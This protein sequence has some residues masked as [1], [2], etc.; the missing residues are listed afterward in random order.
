[1]GNN[2]SKLI[3]I[4]YEKDIPFADGEDFWVIQHIF[5]RKEID[6]AAF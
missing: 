5:Q 4:A 3:D 2:E 1:L 6:E